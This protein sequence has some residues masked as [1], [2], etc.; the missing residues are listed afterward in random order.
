MQVNLVS[1][2][3]RIN[4]DDSVTNRFLVEKWSVQDY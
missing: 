2:N 1:I 3:G 4:F